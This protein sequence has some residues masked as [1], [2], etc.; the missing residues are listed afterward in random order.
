MQAIFIS[1]QA[2][3]ELHIQDIL[4]HRISLADKLG[5]GTESKDPNIQ[6]SN[7]NYLY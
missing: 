3:C 5:T 7:Y 2:S 4:N 1:V 6:M